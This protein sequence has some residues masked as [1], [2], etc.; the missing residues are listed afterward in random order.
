M[1]TNLHLR[2]LIILLIFWLSYLSFFVVAKILAKDK[3]F[4]LRESAYIFGI[5]TFLAVVR[6]YPSFSTFFLG[7]QLSVH[8]PAILNAILIA[9]RTLQLLFLFIYFH[10]L[11]LYTIK[12]TVILVIFTDLIVWII[13]LIR[14][15]MIG[16]LT[17]LSEDLRYNIIASSLLYIVFAALITILLVAITNQLRNRING[18]ATLQTALMLGTLGCWLSIEIVSQILRI[19]S[20]FISWWGI[21]YT[22]GYV[23]VSIISFFIFENS[24]KVKYNLRQKEDEQ[25]HMSF[26]LDEIEQQQVAIRK[27]KHDQQNLFSTID[28]YIQNRDWEG[29]TQ[30]YPKVRTASEIITKN[31]FELEGLS[32]IKMREIKNILIAKLAMAQNLEINTKLEIGEEIDDIPVD[33]VA[34]VRM[35][36]IILDNAIEELQSLGTGRL[37]IGCFKI[38]DSVNIVVQNTCRPDVPSLRQLQQHSFSTKG[39]GRGLGLSNLYEL[40][41][42]L[43]NVALLTSIEDR[44]FTQ[45]LMIG[46]D[47]A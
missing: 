44:Y 46:G 37:L 40:T 39:K 35:L 41:N 36:G 5:S 34:L 13:N 23:I 38:D 19:T 4:G 2:L 26:Y 30:F 22:L 9:I 42:S 8:H 31:E 16:S 6:T 32:Q 25:K 3:S 17:L 28:I 33:P 43:S 7:L 45:T 1:P 14:D 20:S 24:L 27:F 15:F 47:V 21:Y 12:K 10:K 29:L 11:K 18:A